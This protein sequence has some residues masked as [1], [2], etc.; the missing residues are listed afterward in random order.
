MNKWEKELLLEV[1]RKSMSFLPESTEE[2]ER[3]VP[4]DPFFLFS[5][6]ELISV[7]WKIL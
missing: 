6:F 4:L 7:K 3:S 5:D 2:S 1:I